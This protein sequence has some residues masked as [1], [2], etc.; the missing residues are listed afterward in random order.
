MTIKNHMPAESNTSSTDKV[1]SEALPQLQ[2]RPMRDDVSQ[3]I[4]P[5]KPEAKKP[6]FRPKSGCSKVLPE[7]KPR[8]VC[9][10]V[11]ETTST[12]KPEEK[13]HV[14]LP[15]PLLQ[16]K[17]QPTRTVE[18]PILVLPDARAKTFLIEPK[19][20]SRWHWGVRAQ[21][22]SGF[23]LVASGY[24]DRFGDY[25]KAPLRGS[26]YSFIHP[27]GD[28]WLLLSDWMSIRLAGDEPCWVDLKSR[29]REVK[30]FLY[31][32]AAC[33]PT[34]KA[35]LHL[36]EWDDSFT[37]PTSF[38]GRMAE[39]SGAPYLLE[40]NGVRPDFAEEALSRFCS[41]LGLTHGRFQGRRPVRVAVELGSVSSDFVLKRLFEILPDVVFENRHAHSSCRFQCR[42]KFYDRNRIHE[43]NF[44]ASKR[45]KLCKLVK[46]MAL[47]IS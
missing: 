25:H 35:L 42:V 14:L 2:P 24:W 47:E 11:G 19:T 41:K 37:D 44:D 22:Q 10:G 40:V 20:Y 39:P 8:P 1:N 28:E 12:E 21:A 9:A 17:V 46:A 23:E 29:V 43:T 30:A 3:A 33:D 16:E 34:I 45:S 38:F 5:V 26:E 7:L 15:K 4:T 13:D 18:A 36:K 27:R 32:L 31:Y 6:V